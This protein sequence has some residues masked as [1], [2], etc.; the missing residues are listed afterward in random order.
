MSAATRDASG[1][2]GYNLVNR[3]IIYAL[4]LIFAVVYLVPLFVMLV[5]SFK[6]MSEIQDGN[7]LALPQSPTFAPWMRA[8]GG[9]CDANGNCIARYRRRFWRRK[10]CDDISYFFGRYDVSNRRVVGQ[11]LLLARAL[12]TAV[13]SCCRLCRPWAGWCTS[14]SARRCCCARCARMAGCRAQSS[15]A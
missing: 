2:V 6:T 5:T 3:I 15:A 11:A 12:T 14:C 8:W 1:P 4:L 13:S 10:K 7:M 9:G